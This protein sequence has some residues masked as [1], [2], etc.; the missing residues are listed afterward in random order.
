[1]IMY[2]G[3]D[4]SVDPN[5]ATTYDLP[6]LTSSPS[7][8]RL[9]SSVTPNSHNFDNI[10]SFG[11]SSSLDTVEPSSLD[12]HHTSHDDT[13]L[14]KCVGTLNP[15]GIHRNPYGPSFPPRSR[16]T[17]SAFTYPYHLP[18]NNTFQQSMPQFNHLY[19]DPFPD[20]GL[21]YGL[22]QDIRPGHHGSFSESLLGNNF[23]TADLGLPQ[24]P[25]PDDCASVN[26][27]KFSC[28]SDCCS[29]QVCQEEECSGD[30]TPCDDLHCF[31]STAQ[32][33]ED[34]WALNQGWNNPVPSELA[35]S[36]H[37]QHCSHTNTEH[38]VAITLR[39]LR[40]PGALSSPQQQHEFQQQFECRFLDT[41]EHQLGAAQQ[42]SLPVHSHPSLSCTPELDSIPTPTNEPFNGVEGTSQLVCQW[43]ISPGGEGKEICGHVC[44]DSY[45]LHEHLC[46]DHVSLLT[47]KTKYLCLWQGCPRRGDQVF[48]SR[49][50]LRRHLAT[51]TAYKPHKCAICGE[52]FSAQQALDQHVRTHTGETPYKCDF[53]GCGKSFKQKSALTMHKRTHTGEKPLECDICGKC[54]CESSNLSK[55]RKTHNPDYKFKCDEPG[56]TSQFIRIDQLRRHQARHE[57]PKKKQKT[58]IAAGPTIWPLSPET[59]RDTVLEQESS[60]Q[61]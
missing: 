52:G 37:N 36:S 1:M 20:M 24:C 55:H 30:G 54:F 10:F 27:S 33:L 19:P 58:R 25:V 17:V 12:L 13:C 57:R 26:C 7:M 3:M 31:D 32:T 60:I 51:H 6:P 22:N 16:F 28:S 8:E 41:P 56:C 53:E 47:S 11:P 34:I 44:K 14:D 29:T 59:P 21:K 48:A 42:L 45:S 40:A 5:D 38:D 2:G 50:K 23:N 4:D 46:S 43:I 39:D 15:L 9:T 61:A 49:N 35:S 18:E